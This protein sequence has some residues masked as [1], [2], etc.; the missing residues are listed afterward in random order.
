MKFV[1]KRYRSFPFITDVP[2]PRLNDTALMRRHAKMGKILSY[3]VVVVVP[4]LMVM[5]VVIGLLV[6]FL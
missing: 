2:F 4:M 1:L 6:A 5:G 3:I